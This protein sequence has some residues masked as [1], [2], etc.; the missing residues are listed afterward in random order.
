MMTIVDRVYWD[1]SEV[2]C[3]NSITGEFTVKLLCDPYTADSGQ[4]LKPDFCTTDIPK[5][6]GRFKCNKINL[7]TLTWELVSDYRRVPLYHKETKEVMYITELGIDCPST[8]TP[9][10]PYSE[11]SYVVWKDNQWAEDTSLKLEYNKVLKKAEV[12]DSFYNMF[13][14][15]YTSSAVNITV[16]FRRNL[17]ENDLQ[18]YQGLLQ[19]MK[20]NNVPEVPVRDYYNAMTTLTIEQLEQLVNELITYGLYLY[21]KKWQYEADIDAC[22]TQEQL[23]LIHW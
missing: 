3:Y 11:L 13:N 19:Y 14:E 17:N 22:T 9:I 2:Y 12:K 21:N 4:Y 8:H 5:E 15:G 18:N 16:D 10:K 23:D 1:T 20:L 6:P 7:D